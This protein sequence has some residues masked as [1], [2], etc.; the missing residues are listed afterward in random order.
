VYLQSWLR[1]V[2][3]RVV[4]VSPPSTVRYRRSNPKSHPCFESEKNTRLKALSTGV[5]VRSQFFPPS[6]VCSRIPYD[7][8]ALGFRAVEPKLS[9]TSKPATHPSFLSIKCVE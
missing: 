5:A 8:G 1:G 2:S 6:F 4:Q 3:T 9:G 7:L